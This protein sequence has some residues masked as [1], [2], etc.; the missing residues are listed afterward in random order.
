MVQKKTAKKRTTKKAAKKAPVKRGAPKKDFFQCAHCGRDMQTK[1]NLDGFV[2]RTDIGPH[3]MEQISCPC[4]FITKLCPD[5][6]A[7]QRVWNSRPNK[8]FEPE[9]IKVKH[10]PAR[11]MEPGT[12]NAL[13]QQNAGKG[14]DP[15]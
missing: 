8:P 2:Y 1:E 15:F 11:G 14:S 3:M 7:L 4:G 9:R 13:N 5:K 12:V 6:Y 10:P